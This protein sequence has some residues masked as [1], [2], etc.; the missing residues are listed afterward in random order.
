MLQKAWLSARKIKIYGHIYAHTF[1]IVCFVAAEHGATSFFKLLCAPVAVGKSLRRGEKSEIFH[2][3][4][5]DHQRRD[6]LGKQ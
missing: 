5:H 3:Y 1:G 4:H 6:F 2:S